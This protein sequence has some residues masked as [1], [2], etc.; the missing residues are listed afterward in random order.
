MPQRIYR[1]ACWSLIT[2][3]SLFAFATVI[4][5]VFQCVPVQKAW[6]KKQ[7]GSCYPLVDAWYANA[8]FSIITD[9]FVLFLPMRMVYKL[10][11]DLREKLL[12]YCIFGVGIL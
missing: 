4:A 9:V 1:L 7:P 8:I 6:H 3:V 10:Q 2:I 12:L 5:G 11:R